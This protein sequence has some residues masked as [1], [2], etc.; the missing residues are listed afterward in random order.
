MSPHY[1]LSSQFKQKIP[2]LKKECRICMGDSALQFS[3]KVLSIKKF[4]IMAR[5]TV[6]NGIF[7][8]KKI[9]KYSQH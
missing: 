1:S 4:E 5:R 8:F 9:Q 3:R 6:Q 7:I 2:D